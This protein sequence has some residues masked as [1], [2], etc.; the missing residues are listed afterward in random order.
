MINR[1]NF[2]KTDGDQ[3]FFYWDGVLPEG[4]KKGE[5]YDPND[6]PF[7]WPHLK[8]HTRYSTRQGCFTLK[9]S[10]QNLKRIHAQ[11]GKV[12]IERGMEFVNDLKT[13]QAQIYDIAQKVI[14]VKELP[15][16]VLPNP[17]WKMPP[18]GEYQHRGVVFLSNNPVAALFA[19]C[20]MGK[21][22]MVL[23][24]IEHHKRLGIVPDGKTLITVKLA[25]IETGWLEDAV[26]FTG[27]KLVNLWVSPKNKKRKQIILERMKEPADAYV[28][29]HEGIRLFEKDLTAMNFKKIV[30]DESTIL[31]NHRSSGKSGTA[32]GKAIMNVAHQCVWRVIM[33]GTPASNGPADLWGQF[34]FLDPKG[35]ILEPHFFDFQTQHFDV[36]DIRPK[37]KRVNADGHPIPLK[38]RD[39]KLHVPNK[40][41]IKNIHDLT[42]AFTFRVRMKDHLHDM[43]ELTIVQRI[44]DMG[45]EQEKHY[46]MMEKELKVM[47]NEER[48]IATILI[49]Q[50]MKLRQITSGFIIDHN[51]NPHLIEDGAKVA[52]LDS[53]VEDEIAPDL[54]I[55]IYAQYQYEIKM[56]EA[57]YKKHGIVSVYGGN[58]SDKNLANIKK[59]REDQKVR[60]IVLHPKSAAHG[61][62]FTMAHH[63]IFYSF[64]HSAE[65]NYQCVHRIKRNGQKHPMFVYYIKCKNTIDELIYKCIVKKNLNQEE[66]IDGT[67]SQGTAAENNL[68]IKEFMEAS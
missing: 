52:E 32:F 47:I 62:T 41:A 61:I 54:K 29:N 13:S 21:T 38:P 11:F 22:Y 31:K 53:I 12:P 55:V 35:L 3:I 59:F 25:T 63:L 45:E 48:I 4:M 6:V 20:G 28:I 1:F 56:I 66:L 10:K 42:A 2:I 18:I 46:R 67:M 43:P 57:R 34:N 7:F 15:R 44:V 17:Q 50:L 33:S 23:C 40:D 60:M 58:N 8:G 14:K 30:I 19:D 27:L 51:Q 24:S 26:K 65:D 5:I 16:E 37:H 36:V 64:D 39:P 9:F 68:L 49:T